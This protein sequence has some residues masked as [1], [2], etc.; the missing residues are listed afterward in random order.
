MTREGLV[1]ASDSRTNAGYDQIN[2]CRKMHTFVQEG[3][4]VF[5]LMSSGNLSIAQS[6]ITMLRQQFDSGLGL[7]SAETMYDASRVIGEMV[8]R[9]AAIDAA[10]LK[11][12][13]MKF[14]IN[15]VVGG[16]IRGESPAL[17]IIYPQ[18]NPLRATKDTCF[19]Q[20]G[21]AKY[22]KP[23]LDRGINFGK[24]SLQEAAK[25]AILSMDAT[26][27]SN[28]T[29]GPPID[30][31]IY[32]TNAL[33]VTDQRRFTENDP[34]LTEIHG[35]WEQGLRSIVAELPDIDFKSEKPSYYTPRPHRA[36]SQ[37]ELDLTQ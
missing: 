17:Y 19:L 5:V 4:R 36:R 15:I 22:G 30:M 34:C 11:R 28:V 12:D 3:E 33:T 9:V 26:I 23:I 18:G 20:I 25:Y 35:Q 24:T 37:A 7:A 14:N 29:V 27:R 6:V 1:M 2:V 31:L 32:R 8:R 21:D 13:N 16:Q 10:A